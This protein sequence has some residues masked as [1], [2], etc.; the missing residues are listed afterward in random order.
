M[1]ALKKTKEDYKL[2]SL[3]FIPRRNKSN[4]QEPVLVTTHVP[5]V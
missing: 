1:K 4:K 3:F 2:S 5:I